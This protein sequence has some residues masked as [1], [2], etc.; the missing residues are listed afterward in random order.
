MADDRAGL[1]AQP[2][3][4]V[5]VRDTAW[6]RQLEPQPP[7]TSLPQATLPSPTAEAPPVDAAAA[8]ARAKA[9][10]RE[11]Q[12]K[13]MHMFADGP[14]KRRA[15]RSYKNSAEPEGDEADDSS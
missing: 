3:A 14:P 12:W 4:I 9:G 10:F 6:E 1:Q 8:A 13:P 11:M 7:A 2:S 5:S 15:R